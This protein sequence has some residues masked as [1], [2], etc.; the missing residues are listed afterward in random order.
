MT[1]ARSKRDSPGVKKSRVRQKVHSPDGVKQKNWD[2]NIS[3]S[4]YDIYKRFSLPDTLHLWLKI[5]HTDAWIVRARL[6]SEP[7]NPNDLEIER[8]FFPVD[9]FF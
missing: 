7:E 9:E 5:C 3:E 4:K 1:Y 6:G 8:E 2:L